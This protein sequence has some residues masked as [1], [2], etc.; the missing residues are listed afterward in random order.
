M[1]WY[2]V[3]YEI[4]R[5]QG[6]G[7]AGNLHIPSK[8]IKIT[9]PTLSF[10]R[11]GIFYEVG[12]AHS[13][14]LAPPI[15]S[16][17]KNDYDITSLPIPRLLAEPLDPVILTNGLME[18]I[19]HLSDWDPTKPVAVPIWPFLFLNDTYSF[20]IK[21][22]LNNNAR[23][24]LLTHLDKYLSRPRLFAKILT[25][26]RQ[27]LPPDAIL[28]TISPVPTYYT[29]VLA[30]LGVDIIDTG[31]A[32]LMA[33]SRRFIYKDR[34]IPVDNLDLPLCN[35]SACLRFYESHQNITDNSEV[36][37]WLTEH[38]QW[39]FLGAIR[40]VRLLF[41][42]GGLRELV[43]AQTHQ[44]PSILSLIRI[45]NHK[46][47]STLESTTPTFSTHKIIGIG[48]ESLHRPVVERFRERIRTRFSPFATSCV[49]I[50]PCS[51]K[52]PYSNSRSHQRFRKAINSAIPRKHRKLVSEIIYTSPLDL[53][54]RELEYTY[55]AAHY[56]IPVT[57]D[58]SI[59]E[60]TL[61]IQSLAHY[62]SKLSE[63][64]LV[65]SHAESEQQSMILKALEQSKL[66][67]IAIN[68]HPGVTSHTALDELTST[69]RQ[70]Y[71]D[72]SEIT[73]P[74]SPRIRTIH[75]IAD[76]QFGMSASRYLFGND[77]STLKIR[78]WY[79]RPAR[80]FRDQTHIATLNPA[81]GHL[82]LTLNGAEHL[83]PLECI[84]VHFD[85][86][87]LTGSSLFA[88]GV[89]KASHE[90]RPGDEVI[91]ENIHEEIVGTG[92]AI[93]NGYEMGIAN[94][95]ITVKIRRKR[96]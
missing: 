57:G 40:N 22:C 31:F 27:Q 12:D 35:C 9:C 78:S 73:N 42:F 46:F 96:R 17:H 70:V 23:Y 77:P 95:G 93:M 69:L 75:A 36:V 41:R 20:Y 47:Y 45:L 83:K 64:V 33:A 52:K 56:D 38:N 58:W 48:S 91:I 71:P 10:P 39:Q 1:E 87:Q 62:F 21:D 94:K 61:T 53:V 25:S 85:G 80:I 72:F 82:L 37:S 43:E 74:L 89:S 51:A 76:Y 14:S 66:E 11:S 7:R 13:I 3:Y 16:K 6:N 29:S 15:F 54:P 59:E 88:I 81:T 30:Y 19:N 44:S 4:I 5:H 68:T 8:K 86:V 49:V 34:A 84:K 55:P 26:I 79:P 18:I 2:K 32:D 65:L 24:F 50:F 60:Q 90:I 63:N 67:Y 28:H 92:Q